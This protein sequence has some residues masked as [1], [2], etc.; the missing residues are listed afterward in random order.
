MTTLSNAD[1][2]AQLGWTLQVIYD[3]TG[4]RLAWFWRP[5]YGDVDM[6]V[7]AIA[8]EVFGLTTHRLESRARIPL[9]SLH[10]FHVNPPQTTA[11]VT[12]ISIYQEV[13]TPRDP[14]LI[15]KVGCQVL[16]F[17]VVMI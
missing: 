5:P 1:V 4:G 2:V 12:G 6:C 8:K 15:S 13:L 14:K 16:L 3:S 11:P 7:T 9:S 10:P 17:P